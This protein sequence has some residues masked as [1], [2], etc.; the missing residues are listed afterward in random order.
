MVTFQLQHS[1]PLTYRPSLNIKCVSISNKNTG[2]R[3][4]FVYAVAFNTYHLEKL[5]T[6]EILK[7]DTHHTF[8][9]VC[10]KFL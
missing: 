10:I 8:F 4:I 6:I 3:A 1:F 9:K 2:K 7:Y 5:Y